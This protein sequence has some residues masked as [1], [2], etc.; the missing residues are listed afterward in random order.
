MC[1]L[2]HLCS[3]ELRCSCLSLTPVKAQVTVHGTVQSD[4]LLPEDDKEIGAEKTGDVLTN[5]YVDVQSYKE[6]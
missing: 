6:H 3:P 4:V 2:S 5:T 1:F